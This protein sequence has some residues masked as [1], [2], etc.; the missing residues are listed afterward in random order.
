MASSSDKLDDFLSQMKCYSTKDLRK[1]REAERDKHKR[2]IPDRYKNLQKQ[3]LHDYHKKGGEGYKPSNSTS[4]PQRSASDWLKRSLKRMQEKALQTGDDIERIAAIRYGSWKK[5]KDLLEEK[6]AED[7]IPKHKRFSN[8]SEATSSSKKK[9]KRPGESTSK[10][11]HSLTSESKFKH[12]GKAPREKIYQKRNNNWK[13]KLEPSSIET[14]Y[15][16]DVLEKEKSRNL[17][18]NC[19]EPSKKSLIHDNQ[20]NLITNISDV[21]STQKTETKSY[22]LTAEDK[23]RISAKIVKYEISGKIDLVQKLKAKLERSRQA[24]LLL[25]NSKNINKEK[26]SFESDNVITLTRVDRSGVAWPVRN[27]DLQ[28]NAPCRKKTKIRTHDKEGNRTKYYRDDNDYS[29]NDLVARERSGAAD[30][31]HQIISK[32]SA[33]MFQKTDG[34]IFTLDD[35]FESKL[36][37][38]SGK[39]VEAKRVHE[40][41]I[42]ET[43][44]KLMRLEKCQYCLGNQECKEYLIVR[45]GEHSY[46]RLPSH[47]PMCDG[48]CFICPISH[49]CSALTLDENVWEEIRKLMSFLQKMFSKEGKCCIFL[50][51]VTN[52]KNSPHLQIE[53][54]PVKISLFNELPIYFKKALQDSDHN[55]SNKKIIDTHKTKGVRGKIPAGFS[56]FAV[57]FGLDG[58]FAHAVENVDDFPEYFG[59]EVVAGVTEASVELWRKPWEEELSKQTQRVIQ[60]EKK[61]SKD[62]SIKER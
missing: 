32:M 30:Q 6:E 29:L 45:R 8:Q 2:K 52:L 49:S 14:S 3:G 35:M 37:Q 43:R 42:K 33:K 22:I 36:T 10:R 48:H 20:D 21:Q 57:D 55:S 39:V 41:S 61:I 56:Y 38:V 12:D 5:F 19:L 58:G 53:C 17:S 18:T 60:F 1:D 54:I 47:R 50:Q 31:D 25:G 46:I 16:Y 24:E 40:K 15:S 4:K 11:E 62:Y 23:N 59:R 34:D 51:N 27:Q 28:D 9:F 13:R 7:G 44:K 26:E